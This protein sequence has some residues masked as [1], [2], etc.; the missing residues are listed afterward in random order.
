MQENANDD[1]LDLTGDLQEQALHD[2]TT[3]RLEDALEK[4]RDG[5]KEERF[6][7]ILVTTI[8]LNV[9]FFMSMQSFMGPL[10]IGLLQLVGFVLVA[11]KLG[12]EEV[13]QLFDRMLSTIAN[14]VKGGD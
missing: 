6:I 3:A 12:M 14:S 9:C 2:K 8:L 11:K 7:W 5:R 4:E 13:V 10:I 1:N